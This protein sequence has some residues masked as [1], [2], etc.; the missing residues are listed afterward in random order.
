MESLKVKVIVSKVQTGDLQH[1]Y[2]IDS[3]KV[4]D[5]ELFSNAN[6]QVSI[7]VPEWNSLSLEVTHSTSKVELSRFSSGDD[8]TSD[9][10]DNDPIKPGEPTNNEG[11]TLPD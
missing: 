9:D 2:L 3:I 11:V 6:Q 5:I 8:S 7:L 10:D 1:Q 4:G